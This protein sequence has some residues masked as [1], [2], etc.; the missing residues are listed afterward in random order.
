[1]II[2]KA[3]LE[4]V[5]GITS[6]L[7]DNIHPEA[8]FTGRSNVGKSSLINTLMGRKS[9]ARISAK[10]G[11]TQTI[12]YYH[13][14]DQIY[15]VDLPGYGYA[16]ISEKTRAAWDKMVERYLRSSRQL[17]MVFQLIDIRHD[18]TEND[19]RM[20]RWLQSCGFN[21]A[22]IAT[23]LDKIKKSQADKH[24]AAIRSGLDLEEGTPLV[25]FSSVT[26]QGLDEIWELLETYVIAGD[27]AFN[28]DN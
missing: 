17:R 20:Y 8:A 15:I 27:S 18:P 3:E 23:K 22:I 12:N 9:L 2:K 14:N 19:R 6:R 10:P 24:I 28:D 4:T 25:P 1:M 7:P 21:P 16:Q 13:V 11:K 5:C 26:R